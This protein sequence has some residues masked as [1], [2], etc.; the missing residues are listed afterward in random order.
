MSRKRISARIR[1]N[2]MS[3][4]EFDQ[5]SGNEIQFK[6]E[7]IEERPIAATDKLPEMS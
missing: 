1:K 7:S 2:G 3:Q 5:K 4:T 6:S